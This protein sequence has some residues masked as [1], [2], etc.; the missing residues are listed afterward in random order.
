MLFN[1]KMTYPEALKVLYTAIEGK[2][3]KEIA[4]IRSEF[5]SVIPEITKR[6][7]QGPPALTSYKI[8]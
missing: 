7:L 8:D 1:D 5:K 3:K 4:K 6:E 2:S